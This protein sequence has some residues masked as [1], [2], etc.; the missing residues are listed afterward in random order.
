MTTNAINSRMP[1]NSTSTMLVAQ[2]EQPI[3]S[4]RLATPADRPANGHQQWCQKAAEEEQNTE[5]GNQNN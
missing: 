1:T 5:P 3:F 4:S 2:R